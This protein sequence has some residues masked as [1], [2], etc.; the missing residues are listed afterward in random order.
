[1]PVNLRYFICVVLTALVL[2]GCYNTP[3]RHLASDAALIKVGESTR[4]DVLTYLGEPDEQFILKDGEERWLYTEF[5]HSMVK[6]APYV[7]KYFGE[8]DYGT[9]TVKIQ[10]DIVTECVY[11]GWEYNSDDWADDFDWQEKKQ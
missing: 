10:N 7:G 11:D 8:P 6:D 4:N 2:S 9:V 1:M 3:V 5:E